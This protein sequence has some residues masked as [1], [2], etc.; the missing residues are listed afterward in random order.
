MGE[1][2]IIQIGFVICRHKT[3]AFFTFAPQKNIFFKK[4]GRVYEVREWG[5]P[6]YLSNKTEDCDHM[7]KSTKSTSDSQQPRQDQDK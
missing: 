1:V 6:A 3:R 7:G 4:V 2:F 5:K